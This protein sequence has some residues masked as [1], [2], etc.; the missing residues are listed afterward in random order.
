[1]FTHRAEWSAHRFRAGV[2]RKLVSVRAE[3]GLNG[4]HMK[5]SQSRNTEPKVLKQPRPGQESVRCC[6]FTRACASLPKDRKRPNGTRRLILA[7]AFLFATTL[8]IFPAAETQVQNEARNALGAQ[9]RALTEAVA[10]RD[11][12]GV[13]KI[14]TADA[15]L[16]LPGLETVTG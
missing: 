12:A 1:M 6:N 9:R 16:M 13:A 10:R 2:R 15:K 8:K 14:F 3:H 4:V 11:A 5:P 7:C